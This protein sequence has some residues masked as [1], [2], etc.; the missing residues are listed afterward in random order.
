MLNFIWKWEMPLTILAFLITLFFTL[1][2]V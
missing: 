2:R 1:W